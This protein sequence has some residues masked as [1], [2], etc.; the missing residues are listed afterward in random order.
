ME[1]FKELDDTEAGT[2][3]VNG[4]VGN[5]IGEDNWSGDVGVPKLEGSDRFES[6]IL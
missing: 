4:E 1:L 5:D 3:F 6:D 2:I